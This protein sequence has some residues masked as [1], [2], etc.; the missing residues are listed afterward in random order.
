MDIWRDPR[1]SDRF[2]ENVGGRATKVMSLSTTYM[3]QALGRGERFHVV[4]VD[5]DH[6]PE[7]VLNDAVLAYLLLQPGGVL[8]FDD[9]PWKHPDGRPGPKAGIDAF[10]ELHSHNLKVLHHGW[11]VILQK[12]GLA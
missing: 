9:Y 6:R 1:V 3:A 10:M 5:G 12:T 4:Y 7:A 11:Q 8:M 2:D